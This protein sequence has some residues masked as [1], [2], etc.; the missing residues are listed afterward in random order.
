MLKAEHLFLSSQAKVSYICAPP[1]SLPLLSPVH[2]SPAP[3]AGPLL[4]CSLPIRHL[5]VFFR[6]HHVLQIKAHCPSDCHSPFFFIPPCDSHPLEVHLPLQCLS[7]CV[8]FRSWNDEG[9]HN[10]ATF[11][12]LFVSCKQ[13]QTIS[14]HN[15]LSFSFWDACFRE[16]GLLLVKDTEMLW[17]RPLCPFLNA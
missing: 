14:S 2:P 17:D 3:Q 7:F 6:Q 8:S 9:N 16:E 5:C 13:C 11:S 15:A 1:H 12:W 4:L 10:N